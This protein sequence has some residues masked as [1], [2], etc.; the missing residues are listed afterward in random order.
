MNQ[1]IV[2]KFHPDHIYAETLIILRA[3]TEEGREGIYG[4][5]SA[6]YPTAMDGNPDFDGHRLP[7][8]EGRINLQV[9]TTQGA[10]MIPLTFPIP[11]SDPITAARLFKACAEKAIEEYKSESFR[12]NLTVP[13]GVLKS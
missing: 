8:F 11:T 9:I 4:Q 12:R 7:I 1:D 10:G 3:K 13:S 2:P 6:Y 5:I